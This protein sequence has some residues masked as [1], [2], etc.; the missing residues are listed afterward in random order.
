M[1]KII[2]TTLI[3]TTGILL[4]FQQSANAQKKDSTHTLKN[5][6]HFNLTNPMIFGDGSIILGYERVL[7]KRRSFTINI[8]STAF[9]SLDI[10]DADSIKAHSIR[11]NVGFHIS[12]D[13]R[14]YL[15][16]ENKFVAPRG[17][18]LAP[19]YS[20]NNFKNNRSWAVK[21]TSGGPVQEVNSELRLNIHTLGAELGYQFV[22]WKRVA[23][24]MILIGPG[25]SFYNLKA[26]LGANLSTEDR[27]K[28]FDRLNEA[29]EEK[30][31]GY[32]KVFDEGE[33][34]RNGSTN[35]TSIG[36]R[37]MIMVGYRF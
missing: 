34:K 6:I 14:F 10:I 5:T 12:V 1:K 13:Y 28:F 21:S 23:L 19:Y 24:D 33:F 7:N 22:F 11:D 37:Y 4:A 18:Y 16:K 2:C 9:P 30:F 31:P 3:L 26:S 35:T 27:Q 20:F 17:I 8:G 36:F 32:N 25:M 15:A 29:L